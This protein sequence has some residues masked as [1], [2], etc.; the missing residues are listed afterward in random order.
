MFGKRAIFWTAAIFAVSG[1][2]LV[3]W[4]ARRVAKIRTHHR[5]VV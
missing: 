4:H 2:L 3:A 5:V 1:L